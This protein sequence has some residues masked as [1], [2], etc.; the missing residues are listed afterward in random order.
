MIY[1]LIGY[2]W[3]FVHRPFEVWPVLADYRLERIY[4]IAAILC[5]ALFGKKKWIPNPL[6]WA[7]FAFSGAVFLCWV[8]SPWSGEERSQLVVENCFKQLVFYILLVTIITTEADL[9][10]VCL[11][12][13]GVMGMYMV[14]SLREYKAGRHYYRMGIARM[15]GVDQAMNDPNTFAASIVYSLPLAAAFWMCLPTRKARALLIGYAALST[16]CVILTGSRTAMMGLGAWVVVQVMRS[17]HRFR[18]MLPLAAL[19]PIIWWLTPPDLQNRFHTIIDPSVGPVSA[20]QS[21]EQRSEG[22]WIGL[23]LWRQ[24]PL[25]GCGPGAWM[26][27]T[28]AA[29][30]SH[31]LFGQVMGELGLAGVVTFAS[32]VALI[33]WNVLRM[34]Q[35]YKDHPDW[36]K[37]FLWYLTDALGIAVLLLLFLGLSSHNLYRYS[38]QW[39]G[40]FLII[41][42]HCVELRAAA[43]SACQ[44]RDELEETPNPGGLDWTVTQS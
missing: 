28:G 35:A 13:L 16:L 41:A 10:K 39:F 4:M 22:F 34:K 5:W 11:A 42:R 27:A 30:E 31:Q 3:L 32:I 29:I 19:V 1:L 24:Y 12:F 25:G 20:Q 2:I 7:F 44:E 38:W 9:K 18:L 23:R 21:A 17:R 6:H 40:A 14:H 26:P 8:A 43:E 37:D 36:D 15:I 33:G